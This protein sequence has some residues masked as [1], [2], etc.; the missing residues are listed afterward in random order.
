MSERMELRLEVCQKG[1]IILTASV[2]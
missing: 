2:V 1:G